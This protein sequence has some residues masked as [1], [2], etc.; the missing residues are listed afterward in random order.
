MTNYCNAECRFCGSPPVHDRRLEKCLS[1][2]EA[3]KII[4]KAAK[5][6]CKEL[7]ITGGEPTSRFSDLIE[8]IN[9]T[10]SMGM[11]IELF[12]NS[13]YAETEEKT[14]KLTSEMV[15]AGL[16]QI[17]FSFDYDHLIFNPYERYLRAIKNALEAGLE[18][19][20][21]CVDRKATRERNTENIKKLARDLNGK[22]TTPFF[23]INYNILNRR[24]LGEKSWILLDN[25]KIDVFRNQIICKGFAKKLRGEFNLKDS[26]KLIFDISM[27]SV[28]KMIDYET[29]A[30][31]YDGKIILNCCG[32]ENCF[33]YDIGNLEK[34][35]NEDKAT[36][37]KIYS[38]FGFLSTFL[39]IKN[40][41]HKTGKNF[42]KEKYPTKCDLCVDMLKVLKKQNLEGPSKNQVLYFVIKHMDQVIMRFFYDTLIKLTVK[43]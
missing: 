37:E 41:E 17:F 28:R 15:K 33:K 40:L 14:I 11:K 6:G 18:V 23:R 24:T 13:F 4:K 39:S 35:L 5:L 9:F 31:D 27:C 21:F 42:L 38:D 43:T 25:S 36:L 30:V 8:I 29:I 20:I 32:Y 22:Y 19:K 2:Q 26:E 16:N 10:S 1:V 34:K 7:R 12:T 3:K